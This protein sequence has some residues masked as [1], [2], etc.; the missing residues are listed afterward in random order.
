MRHREKITKWTEGSV[1]Y[2][3]EVFVFGNVHPGKIG[4]RNSVGRQVSRNSRENYVG[5]WERSM[6]LNQITN[7]LSELL[8]TPE[9]NEI[10]RLGLEF[11]RKT[12]ISSI[13]IKKAVV[14]VDPTLAAIDHAVDMK[15]NLLITHHPLLDDE[16]LSTREI[17]FEKM[18]LLTEHNIWVYTTGESWNW[19]PE[20]IVDSTC[21]ALK[22]PI[23]DVLRLALSTGKIVPAGRLCRA[24]RSWTLQEFISH[25]K[26]MLGALPII[27]GGSPDASIEAI[28][29]IGNDFSETAALQ[30]M[31]LHKISILVAGELSHRM[32]CLLSDLRIPFCELSHQGMD[33]LGMSKLKTLLSIRHPNVIFELHKGSSDSVL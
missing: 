18:R 11:G 12:D 29:I 4:I 31:I 15:A 19:A 25:A 26:S 23:L 6:Y 7:S 14:S 21:Q 10:D 2:S 22:L 1:L 24:E 33:I 17:F 20:G 13:V 5:W 32:K 30:S 9:I 28:A 8:P 3:L 16:M 27:Y